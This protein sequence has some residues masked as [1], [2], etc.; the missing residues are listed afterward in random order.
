MIM[1]PWR[2]SRPLAVLTAGLLALTA[3]AGCASEVQ[4]TASP[5]SSSAAA[6]SSKAAG[7]TG[8]LGD[9]TDLS[10]GLLPAAAFGA[11]GQVTPITAEQISQQSKMGGLGGAGGL[12]ITPES[13]APAVTSVQPGL[14]DLEGFAAQAATSGSAATVEILAAG[15]G[16]ADGVDQLAST[17]QTCPQ[18]TI[19]APRVGTAT[20][21]FGAL[22]VPDLGDG[23]AGLAM[24]T[25][26][27]GPDGQPL[28]VAVL[29]GMARDGDRLVS[30]TSTDPTGA[31]DPT[32]FAALLRQAYEHQA[33]ALD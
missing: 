21:V 3:V 18:A 15:A 22:D 7:S 10:A 9:A 30:L 6:G 1:G 23:S 25:T 20:I 33:D 31:S 24:T 4:G 11:D 28:T 13:C 17:A 26:V 12:T 16:I 2:R 27:T 19:T 8:A 14:D 29:L 32:A 5:D